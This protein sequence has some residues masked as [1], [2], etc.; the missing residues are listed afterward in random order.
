MEFRGHLLLNIGP[1]PDG[2]FPEEAKEILRE[3]DK[4]LALNGEAIYGTTTW[5]SYSEGPYTISK[6][7][8]FN[9]KNMPVFDASDVRFTVK[10]QYL[11]AICLGWPQSP[12]VL[13]EL[14]LLWP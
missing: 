4:W 6:N 10:D 7:G 2:T 1:K 11:Y 9:E 5:K 3:M 14:K 12:P 13:G 8:A